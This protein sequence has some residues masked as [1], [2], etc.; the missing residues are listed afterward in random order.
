MTTAQRPAATQHA[1]W[2]RS[3]GAPLA[4]GQAPVPTPGPGEIVVANRAVA[5]NPVDWIVRDVGRMIFPWLKT[6]FVLGSDLAGD[7]V[8]VGSGVTRFKVGDRVLGHAAGIDKSRSSSA[9]GSFQEQTV[10]LERMAAPIPE[11]MSYTDAAVL[12]LG[13]STAAC[14]LFQQDH[15][16]LTHPQAA[17]VAREQTVLI[18]GGSSNVGSNAIQLVVCL[19]NSKWHVG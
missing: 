15:L 13:I 17:P 19:Q 6:P 4:V 5:M 14:A 16:A 10:V 7:V 1:A 11:A 12:P 8:Q 2:W 3:N 9:E 18:W